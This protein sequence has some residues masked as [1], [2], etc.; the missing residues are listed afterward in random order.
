[1]AASC[2]NCHALE[3]LYE[4]LHTSKNSLQSKDKESGWTPLHRAIYYG[5]IN[6]AVF[7]FKV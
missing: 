2:G 7:L 1:M 5:H 3:Y 4:H 6:C